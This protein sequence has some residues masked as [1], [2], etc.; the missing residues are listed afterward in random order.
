VSSWLI[1]MPVLIQHVRSTSQDSKRLEGRIN[2]DKSRNGVRRSQAPG[3]RKKDARL[4][5][6]QAPHI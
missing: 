1:D 6:R 5:R 3:G 4:L 2:P